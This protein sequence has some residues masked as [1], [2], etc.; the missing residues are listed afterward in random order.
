M[1]LDSDDFVD[2]VKLK[3]VVETDLM[4]NFDILYYNFFQVDSTHNVLK[5][6]DLIEFSNFS[7]DDLILST[8]SWKLPWGQFKIIKR[9]LI[10][11]SSISFMTNTNESEELFFTINCLKNATTIKF[12]D[13]YL[14]YYVKR[15]GSLSNSHNIEEFYA[16]R[17]KM[18]SFL[19]KNVDEK[20]EIGV[21]NY[22]YAS[23]IQFIKM[24][25]EN[26][27]I[28]ESIKHYKTY[29]KPRINDLKKEINIRYLEN[30]YVVIYKILNVKMDYL[31]I[32]L[33]RIRKILI[34]SI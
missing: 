4:D 9:S 21:L 15:M 25:S 16:Q 19:R 14:Y 5:R 30:R 20:Y 2:S 34:A 3:L 33:F 13:Y 29:I 23:H 6:F 18:I 27:S 8:L 24:I 7:K 1:F 32:A 26:Y 31:L 11:D 22:E 12:L 10:I 28:K 17:L